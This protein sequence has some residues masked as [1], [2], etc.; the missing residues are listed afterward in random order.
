M[1]NYNFTKGAVVDK[2]ADKNDMVDEDKVL[3]ISTAFGAQ[4]CIDE[5]M[6][7]Q[8]RALYPDSSTHFQRKNYKDNFAH[9]APGR[10][11]PQRELFLF[12]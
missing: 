8:N 7:A 1:R 10:L 11:D 12:S 2:N 9:S 4:R 6:Q 5:P 3:I